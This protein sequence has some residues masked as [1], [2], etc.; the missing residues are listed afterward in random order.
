MTDTR[1]DGG[2]AFPA[3]QGKWELDD[4]RGMSLRDWFAGQAL[5]GYCAV[6]KGWDQPPE[7]V[8]RAA[9]ATADAMIAER[10]K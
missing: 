4:P 3:Y 6:E 10:S 5:A 8:A 2:P 9:F 1:K 7:E